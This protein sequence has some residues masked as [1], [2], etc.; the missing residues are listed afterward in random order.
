LKERKETVDCLDVGSTSEV[1]D[2]RPTPT[3]N[4]NALGPLRNGFQRYSALGHLRKWDF[5]GYSLT[6]PCIDDHSLDDEQI[7]Y[8]L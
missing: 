1:R 4:Y 6:D 5:G 2:L 8:G 7:K 3:R